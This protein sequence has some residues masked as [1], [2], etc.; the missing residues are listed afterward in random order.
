MKR[1][2]CVF[3]L[4]ILILDTFGA[5][6]QSRSY[7]ESVP[8]E[9]KKSKA[10]KRFEWF[11]RQRAFP[12]DT[13][14]VE[15][16]RR[17]RQQEQ[18]RQRMASAQLAWIPIGPE[19]VDYS[20]A[21]P[22]RWGVCAGRVRAIAVHPA[23]AN[24]VYIGA[25]SGGIW[26]TTDGGST[27]ASL[28]DDLACLSFGAIAIDPVDPANVYAGSGEANLSLDNYTYEGAGLFRST[29]AGG[30][31]ELINSDFGLRTS[32]AALHVNPHNRAIVFAALVDNRRTP[33]SDNAGLWRSTDAGTT[34]TSV[35]GNR[36]VFD[37][38]VHPNPDSS[39]IV[40]ASV[41]G[42]FDGGFYISR[43]G[44]SSNSWTLSVNGLPPTPQIN[45]MQISFARSTLSTLYAVVYS[46]P[47]L[48]TTRAFKSTNGGESWIHISA[49]VPLGGYRDFLPVGYW[50]DQGW[51]DLCIAVNPAN[52]NEVYVGN[53]ELHRTMDGSNFSPVRV[54][55]GISSW[56][57]PAHV[58][59]H[60]VAFAPSGGNVMY[61]GCDGGVYRSDQG[62]GTSWTDINSG[63]STTQF[64]RL[65]SHPSNPSFIMGGAQDNG[66]FRTTDGG[67]G[68]WELVNGGD[69]MECFVD[70][71]YPTIVYASTQNGNLLRSTDGGTWGSFSGITSGLFGRATWVAPFFMHPTQSNTLYTARQRPFMSTDR[72]NTW[73]PL[74]DQDIHWPITAMAQ[75]TANPSNMIFATSMW[76]SP[77]GPSIYSTSDG[78][79]T[80]LP[81][82]QLPPRWISRLVFHPTEGNTAFAVVSGFSL[83]TPNEPGHIFRSTN[84]GATWADVTSNLPDVPC[85]DLFVDPQ[86]VNNYYVANDLGV[87]FSSNSGSSWQR[88][89]IGMPFVPAMDFSYFGA[90]RMLRVGT[91]G[92]GAYQAPL[93]LSATITV[94]SPTGGEA[95]PVGGTRIVQWTSVNMP[96]NVN[97]KLSTNGGTIFPIDLASN[98]TNDGIETIAVPNNPS[99]ACRVKIES[100]VQPA[101]FG[102]SVGTFSISSLPATNIPVCDTTG[103]QWLSRMMKDGAG[104][105]YATWVDERQGPIYSQ[106]DIYV[107][108][109]NSV[110]LPVWQRNGVPICAAPSEQGS[111]A[112]TTD[113]K[114][115]AIIA[116]TDDRAGGYTRNI[117]AQRISPLGLSLWT[118]NG[119]PVCMLQ[120]SA[121]GEPEIIDDGVGGAIVAWEDNRNIYWDIYAQRIDSTG[122]IRWAQNGVPISTAPYDQWRPRMVAD[123]AGGAIIAWKDARTSPSNYRLYAQRVDHSGSIRW[124]ADGVL[125]SASDIIEGTSTYRHYGI[126]PDSSGGAFLAWSNGDIFI[127]RI[128]ALGSLLWSPNGIPIC[129]LPSQQW[130]PAVT[131]QNGSD[132]IISWRDEY[133][134][135][136]YAQRVSGS[137]VVQWIPNGVRLGG[138]M[139]HEEPVIASDDIGG[140]IVTWSQYT[141]PGPSNADIFAQRIDQ[142]GNLQW[143]ADGVDISPVAGDQ[144]RPAVV[145]DA[146]VSAIV[147]WRDNRDGID[148]DI[149]AHYV[150]LLTE[151]SEKVAPPFVSALL[152]N[153]PNP[154]N[155]TTTIE[156]SVLHEQHV[157]LK[158]YDVLCRE[159]ITLVNE[160]K[161]PGRY[162]VEWNA[163]QQ[164]SGVYFYRLHSGN[165]VATKKLLLLR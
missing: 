134:T 104:G 93:P 14:S 68:A 160:Q 56:H 3:V 98:T 139:T 24:I 67:S 140:A 99:T 5:R 143:G 8:S 73:I 10:Y 60:T 1:N 116:W 130:S 133:R 119:V 16:F 102:T 145:T 32:F 64:Y 19:G 36:D 79:T 149:Y 82:P 43:D 49:G 91:H 141:I 150:S 152:Q 4:L 96:G 112:I 121:R 142:F 58:D 45:R 17:T 7:W 54:F 44:G 41:G 20:A 76:E 28:S 88:E 136:L 69:G 78:G 47:P 25:A 147:S 165:F 159:V 95:W 106:R 155:P 48:D 70:Y 151:V 146:T 101:I 125:V 74:R 12:L 131:C 120:G 31:W 123:G 26:K 11:Y 21:F 65:A 144:F 87:Y 90:T 46:V 94:T 81:Q 37:V 126:A 72:G 29:N 113:G 6:A 114:G 109:M 34:W 138:G 132:V 84:L 61:L 86:N 59:Y 39:S 153:Y 163:T 162:R 83:S 97:I 22:E 164:A 42:V 80:W 55:P 27:W 129:V 30:T 51:Y 124:T 18:A 117:Y 77:Y 13:I 128:N 111:P 156:Y 33:G 103:D 63:I 38:T 137:G 15:A 118:Q 89:G 110:G 107:Q 161:W 158:V 135:G 71:S 122:V 23:N 75:S 2:V 115:G 85:N 40:Y 52:E 105:L 108:R 100:V 148:L 92:R 157:L 62:G 127:Q 154:F 57:S 35:L 9:I 53:I 66:V 50:E